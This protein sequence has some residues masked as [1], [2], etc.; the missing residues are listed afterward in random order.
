MK[1]KQRVSPCGKCY[2]KFLDLDMFGEQI[3]FNISGRS[4][5]GTFCGVICTLAIILVTVA[6]FYFAL[7]RGMITHDVPTVI[8]V[9]KHEYFE[10]GREVYQVR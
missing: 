8:S 3:N 5:F 6:A 9:V 4:H 2:L 1:K 10:P 7:M